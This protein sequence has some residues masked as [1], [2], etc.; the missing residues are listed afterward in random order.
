MAKGSF[1]SKKDTT[2]LR[3]KILLEAAADFARMADAGGTKVESVIKIL[4]LQNELQEAY[5]KSCRSSPEEKDTIETE[6]SKLFGNDPR[7]FNE[8]KPKDICRKLG[9]RVNQGNQSR[10]WQKKA[11]L[12]LAYRQKQAAE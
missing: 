12:L 8:V 6:M 11:Q 7:I 2:M 1:A 9:I 10:V 4:E 5:E 3:T